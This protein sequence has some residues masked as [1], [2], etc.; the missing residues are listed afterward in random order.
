MARFEDEEVI[1]GEVVKEER[2]P[3]KD[4]QQDDNFTNNLILAKDK[5]EEIDAITPINTKIIKKEN[6]IE[7]T[8]NSDDTIR[9]LEKTKIGGFNQL[10][11]TESKILSIEERKRVVEYLTKQGKTQ[12]EIAKYIGNSQPTISLDLDKIEKEKKLK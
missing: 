12:E 2:L 7:A 5:L 9:N 6:S 8:F 3:D 1:K 10:I 11:Y 4:N